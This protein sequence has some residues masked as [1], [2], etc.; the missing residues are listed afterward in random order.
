MSEE[1]PRFELEF[2]IRMHMTDDRGFCRAA[3]M[4]RFMQETATM[5]LEQYGPDYATLCSRGQAFIMSRISIDFPEPVRYFDVL[6]STSWPCASSRGACFDRDFVIYHGETEAAVAAS[7][8]A[9][10]D[11]RE[12][13]LLRVEACDIAFTREEQVT[14]TLPLRFRIPKDAVLETLG[15]HKVSYSDIDTN[16]HMNNTRYCDL[17]CDFLPM[18]GK[19][20]AAIAIAFANEATAADTIMVTGST[21][22]DENGL[23]YIR[24]YRSSDNAV[25][26]EAVVR[27]ENL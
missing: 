7:Q 6:R 24:T 27:L 18:Q 1:Y 26:T 13:K 17:Y 16:R 14:T 22:P 15:T 19:R 12:H 5:Q 8:W 20:I 2:P 25:N 4:M 9:F 10:L 11:V 23:Y 21:E 3:E